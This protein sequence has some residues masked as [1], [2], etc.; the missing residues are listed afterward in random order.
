MPKS[1]G[2]FWLGVSIV[3]AV[4]FLFL[5]LAFPHSWEPFVQSDLRVEL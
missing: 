5:L 2:M 4:E 3:L 1:L